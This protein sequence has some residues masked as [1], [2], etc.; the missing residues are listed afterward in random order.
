LERPV[1]KGTEKNQSTSGEDEHRGLRTSTVICTVWGHRF[2]PLTLRWPVSL[3][4]IPEVIAGA[5][6][7]RHKSGS[8]GAMVSLARGVG[9][10]F[11][12]PRFGAN[13]VGLVVITDS[14][15]CTTGQLTDGWEC[16]HGR[17]RGVP[18]TGSFHQPPSFAQVSDL[19][20]PRASAPLSVRRLCWSTGTPGPGRVTA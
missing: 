17:L 5:V 20:S 4:L 2:P 15:S 14:M 6:L 16:V 10:V 13:L 7:R 3:S 11:N 12:P 9:A 19:C 18:L 8:A 1:E